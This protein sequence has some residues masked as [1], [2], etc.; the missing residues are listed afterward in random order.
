MQS[1]VPQL[2]KREN[3]VW[4]SLPPRPKS[5]VLLP[6]MEHKPVRGPCWVGVGRGLVIPGGW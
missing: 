5:A 1:C 4:Y 6:L 3:L 2:H